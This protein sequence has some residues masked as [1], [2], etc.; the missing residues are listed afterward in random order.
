MTFARIL[1][2][3]AILFCLGCSNKAGKTYKA[4]EYKFN[5]DDGGYADYGDV[6]FVE[7]E[8]CEYVVVG[9]GSNRIMAHKG[10]CKNKI[11]Q[12]NQVAEKD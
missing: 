5:F 8:G 2:A 7:V 11:H 9:S 10:N 3:L 1:L 4:N 12:H 6:Y